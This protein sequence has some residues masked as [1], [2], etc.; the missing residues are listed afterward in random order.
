MKEDNIELTLEFDGLP[1]QRETDSPSLSLLRPFRRIAESGKPTGRINYVFFQ[2]DSSLYN[3]GSLC[4]SPRKLLLF[5]PGLKFRS[6][7]WFQGPNHTLREDKLVG[8]IDHLTLE[9]SGL[10]LFYWLQGVQV[11]GGSNPLTP[12]LGV[13]NLYS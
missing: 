4:Y 10:R 11:V 2:E 7:K 3:L 6:I 5:F 12:T 13:K 9:A 1:I 8:M